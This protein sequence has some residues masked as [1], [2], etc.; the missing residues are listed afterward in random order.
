M[1]VEV[2]EKI[3][4]RKVTAGPN[5][6]AEL[7]YAI[8][9]TEN[10]AEARTYLYSNTPALFEVVG[11]FLPRAEAEIVP[12]GWEAWV[13]NVRY[14]P[15]PQTE[16]AVYNFDTGGGTAHVMY[17]R[18]H[19][20]SFAAPGRQAPSHQGA[21]GVT[22]DGTIE[23]VDIPVPVF[24]FSETHY[25]PDEFVTPQYKGLLAR[26]TG[27]VNA[28]TFRGLEAGE[29]LFLGASGTKRAIADWEI[30][31]RF[32]GSPNETDLTV[33]NITGIPKRG[34]EYLWVEYEMVEDANRLATRP[35][36]AHVEEVHRT[37]DLN[38]LMI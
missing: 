31:Y 25:L 23:G 32:A 17:A 12:D 27:C 26:L 11:L 10:E 30:T 8:L 4:S 34:W 35:I 19:V 13:A 9:G 2:L 1:A 3:E 37:G 21:I 16:D 18:R 14:A 6:S 20:A 5:P 28:A 33:G 7:V 22:P 38:Q 24:Q 15:I 29:C 36:A